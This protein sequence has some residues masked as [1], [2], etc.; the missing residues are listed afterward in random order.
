MWRLQPWHSNLG[1]RYIK[2]PKLYMTDSG[3]LAHLMNA[4]AGRVAHDAALAGQVFETFVAM[5]LLRQ[6]EW[7]RNSPAL[8]HYRDSQ[9]REIDVV[10]EFR[11]G[12]VAGVEV[13]TAATIT[14]KDS[15]GSSSGR[16]LR[17]AVQAFSAA[18]T[19]GS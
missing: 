4:D 16:V 1:S 9:Q 17:A 14:S 18:P 5:E 8:F 11:G 7:S 19:S 13:K 12:A 3:L 6:R 15:Q 10:M 2:T